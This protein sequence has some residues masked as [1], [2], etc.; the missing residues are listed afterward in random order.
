MIIDRDSLAPKQ[1]AA[2]ALLPLALL[3]LS[4]LWQALDRVSYAYAFREDTPVEYAQFVLL[5]AASLFGA[6]ITFA[7]KT[8]G[9]PALTMLYAIFAL[10]LLAVAM[11]EISWGQR[12]IGFDTPAYFDRHNLQKEFNLHNLDA[13]ERDGAGIWFDLLVGAAV[14]YMSLT[15]LVMSWGRLDQGSALTHY[16]VPSAFLTG[17]FL[18][19]TVWMA[20][21]FLQ[22]IGG[23]PLPHDNENA[24]LVMALGSFL[25]MLYGVR[26]LS[27]LNEP[28]RD[29]P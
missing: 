6:R 7:M 3:L 5:L 10:A 26:R 4:E 29:I 17:Y 18:L 11:E 20:C 8:R 25:F 15:W 1:A 19:P 9:Y 28:L 27:L 14:A 22:G 2:V 13:I 16:F 23:P 24:E 12:L 21:P